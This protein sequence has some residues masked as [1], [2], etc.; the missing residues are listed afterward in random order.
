[1]FITKPFMLI[2][3]LSDVYRYAY[4]ND[5]IVAKKVVGDIKNAVAMCGEG[6]LANEIKNEFAKISD[7]YLQ[8]IE[9]LDLDD[10]LYDKISRLAVCYDTKIEYANFRRS[11]DLDMVKHYK[12]H[13]STIKTIYN[14][15]LDQQQL[16][17]NLI[18]S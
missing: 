17:K 16:Y 12:E 10:V 13:E 11:T 7:K 2:I 6:K 1:M 14:L 4:H 5:H 18:T 3:Y 9:P 8:S 15:Y